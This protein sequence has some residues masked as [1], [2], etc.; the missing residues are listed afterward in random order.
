MSIRR[1]LKK[2]IVDLIS[3]EEE[4]AKQRLFEISNF[5]DGTQEDHSEI[6]V[7]DRRDRT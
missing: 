4:N 1:G 5:D 6:L 2:K 7:S 3:N